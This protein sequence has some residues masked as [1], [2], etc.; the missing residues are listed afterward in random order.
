MQKTTNTL[1]TIAFTIGCFGL[2]LVITMM[3][4]IVHQH[5][6][7]H[8]I[9]PQLPAFSRLLFGMRLMFIIIPIPCILYSG[10]VTVRKRPSSEANLLYLGILAAL[11]C[12]FA[13]GVAVATLLPWLPVINSV[14]P[15]N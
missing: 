2:W 8:Q 15:V 13:L 5:Q 4:W 14:K 12:F 3:G 1:L 6:V 11:F 7:E 9:D 10:F